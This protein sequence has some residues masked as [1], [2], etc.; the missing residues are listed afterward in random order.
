MPRY[1]PVSPKRCG[2]GSKPRLRSARVSVCRA[3]ST[4]PTRPCCGEK[5][6]GGLRSSRS[7]RSL[8]PARFQT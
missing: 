3:A 7:K 6:E 2:G 5:P 1:G 4:T 8:P